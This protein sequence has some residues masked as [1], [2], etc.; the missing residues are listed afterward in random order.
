MDFPAFREQLLKHLE[1]KTVVGT[2][3]ARPANPDE[4]Y[5]LKVENN[6]AAVVAGAPNSLATVVSISHSDSKAPRPPLEARTF[7][8]CDVYAWKLRGYE[9]AP[10]IELYWTEAERDAAV[11]EFVIFLRTHKDTF[12]YSPERAYRYTQ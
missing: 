7:R 3:V 1:D 5:D 11:A 4:K 2:L 9:G 10:R 6:I 8:V 12:V